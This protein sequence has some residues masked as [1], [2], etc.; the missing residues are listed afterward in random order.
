[1]NS[2]LH[3]LRIVEKNAVKYGGWGTAAAAGAPNA[4]GRVQT[5]FFKCGREQ[6]K[7][8]FETIPSF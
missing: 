4:A 5:N 2:K 1:M 6:I 7:L 8:T 3:T